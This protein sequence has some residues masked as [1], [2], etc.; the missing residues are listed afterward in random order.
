MLH[1]V[2]HETDA[3]ANV[4]ESRGVG[5]LHDEIL[6]ETLLKGQRHEIFDLCRDFLL[7]K[8]LVIQSSVP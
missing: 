8:R 3:V 1:K 4:V 2:A 5:S 7:I 6:I